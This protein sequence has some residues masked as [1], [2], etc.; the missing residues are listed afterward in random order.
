[1]DVLRRSFPGLKNMLKSFIR[2]GKGIY[3]FNYHQVCDVFDP[4]YHNKPVFTEIAAFEKQILVIKKYF[5]VI[6]VKDALERQKS[7]DIDGL[8]AC[9][10]VDDGFY[11]LKTHIVPALKKHAVPATFFINTAYLGNRK[12]DWGT[13]NNYMINSDL[14][15]RIPFSIPE[16]VGCMRKTQDKG[17]YQFLSAKIESFYDL[18]PPGERRFFVDHDFLKSIEHSIF[19]IGLHGHEHQRY[20][21]M[22]DQWK[23]QDLS[24]NLE[25]LSRYA[26]CIHAFAV[27]FGRPYDWDFD[28][29]KLCFEYDLDILFADGGVNF[30]GE[31]GLK[32]IPAD[33]RRIKRLLYQ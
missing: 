24:E 13:V 20:A 8:F 31:V 6:T 14:L 7:G 21:L 10:T 12:A 33:G 23:R 5:D 27:P 17:R 11:S 9:V 29:V 18:I 30:G 19:H 32:R 2:G 28:T 1:M 15:E 25:V 3:V 26:N 16:D 22:S 4:R